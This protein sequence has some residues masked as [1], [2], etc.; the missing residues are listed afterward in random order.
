[1]KYSENDD[2][3]YTGCGHQIGIHTELNPKQK[4]REAK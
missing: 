4:Y 3:I 2:R 1:M